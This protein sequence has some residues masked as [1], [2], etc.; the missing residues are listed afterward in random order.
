MQG[1]VRCPSKSLDA[2][3]KSLFVVHQ[4]RSCCHQFFLKSASMFIVFPGT[5]DGF[6]SPKK[7]HVGL[8]ATM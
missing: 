7:V 2:D 5:D 3:E 8:F 6:S 4:C 1:K